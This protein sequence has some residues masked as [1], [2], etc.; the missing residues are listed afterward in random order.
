MHHGISHVVGYPPSERSG[1][2]VDGRHPTGMLSC[3]S[4]VSHVFI[5]SELPSCITGST[6]SA[7]PGSCTFHS[8]VMG[9]LVN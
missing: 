7:F 9:L 4:L 8:V 3:W 2:Q 5:N 1:F 6:G